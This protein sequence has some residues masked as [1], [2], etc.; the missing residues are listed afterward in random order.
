MLPAGEV[1]IYLAC[2]VTDMR[3]GF[4]SL[5]AQVQT[6]LNHDPYTS[7]L[8]I[9][10]GRRG[11]LIKILFWDR[12]GMCLY[13]KKLDR[14]RFIWPQAKDGVV[15]LTMAQLSMLLESIRL[16][17]HGMDGEARSC[18]VTAET[19]ASAAVCSGTHVANRIGSRDGGSA[20]A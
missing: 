16:A 9:F 18:C 2:G 13:A 12:Q 7:A 11:D 17:R 19:S 5:A 10:R 8:Y 20:V 4:H 6:T 14:G 1:R 15:T 3:K